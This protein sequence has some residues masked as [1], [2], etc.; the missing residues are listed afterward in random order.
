MEAAILAKK[1]VRRI[2]LSKK[3]TKKRTKIS[4][5]F[6]KEEIYYREKIVNHTF[7]A[8]FLASN[9]ILFSE[10]GVGACLHVL[11]MRLKTLH[12]TCA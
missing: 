12:Q 1:L 10:F 7:R 3:Q 2:T 8:Y 11:G 9:F 4:D 5:F 6:D